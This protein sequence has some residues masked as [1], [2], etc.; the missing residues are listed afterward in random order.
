MTYY[1]GLLTSANEP[2]GRSLTFAYDA[3]R[4]LSGVTDSAGRSVVYTYDSNGNL[5]AVKDVRDGIIQYQYDEQG[6][7]TIIDPD[8][9]MIWINSYDSNSRVAW[10]YDSYVNETAFNHD[11]ANL[12]T[13]MTDPLGNT[14]TVSYDDKYRGTGITYPGGITEN[15]TYDANNCP[16]SVTDALN[17]TTNYE[18]DGSGNLKY[19]TDPA[20]QV[21]SMDYDGKNNLVKVINAKSKITTLTYDTDHINLKEVIDPLGR[22]TTYDFYSNGL[23]HTKKT[24]DPDPGT[25]IYDYQ[26]GLLYTLTDPVGNITTCGYDNFGYLHTITDTAGKT[27]AMNYDPAGNLT[28]VTDPLGYNT[29]FTYDYRH[30]I[31]TKTDARGFVTTYSYNGNGQLESVLDALNNMTQY[32]YDADNRL[33]KI[34]DARGNTTT[35]SYNALG[36]LTGTTDPLGNTTGFQYNDA[37]ILTIKTDAKGIKVLE[38]TYNELDNPKKMTD[39]LGKFVSFDEYD[40]LGSLTKYTDSNG[41]STQFEYNDLNSL[42]KTTVANNNIGSQDFDTHGNRVSLI[43]PNNNTVSF[44]YD[45]ADRLRSKSTVSAGSISMEYNNRNLLSLKTNARGQITT[46]EYD[47][48]G[49]LNSFTNPDGTTS[50]IYDQNGNLLT[51]TDSTGTTGRVYDALNRLFKYTDAQGNIIQYGYDAVGNLLTLTYPGGR[52][53]Q[54]GYDAA[55]QLKTVTD[56]SGRITN[57]DYDVNGRLVKTTRPDGTVETREYNDAGQLTQLKD[58]YADGSIINRY[59]YTY[60]DAGN[61]KTDNNTNESDPFTTNNAVLTYAADNRLDT[62]EGQ[63]VQYDADGNMTEGPLAENMVNFTFDARSRLTG[64]GNTSYTYDALNNRVR[65]SDG[66]QQTSYTINPNAPLSQVLIQTD[67]ENTKT[68]FVYGLGLIGQETGGDYRSYHFDHLGSTIALTDQSGNVTDCFRYAPYGE[69]LYRSGN[70]TTP[71]LFNGR[72]GVMTDAYDLYYMR[73]R[74]YNPVAKRFISPDTL[75]G[76]ITNPQSQN[77]YIYCEGNPVNYVDPMGFSISNYRVDYPMVYSK[78]FERFDSYEDAYQYYLSLP[79]RI[80][81]QV[82]KNNNCLLEH[83]TIDLYA[84]YKKNQY[85][86]EFYVLN[87]LIIAEGE[88]YNLDAKKEAIKN[89]QEIEIEETPIIISGNAGGASKQI[90]AGILAQNRAAGKAAELIV[91]ERLVG[92]GSKIIGSQVS[93][94]TPQG[95]RRTDHLIRDIND[96][97][98]AIEVKSGNATRNAMQIAKDIFIETEGGI[99]VGSNAGDLIGQNVKIITI[100]ERVP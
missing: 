96:N 63:N 90:R 8:D 14:I 3:S 70:I 15:F 12:Q 68:Y 30:N 16:K 41:V 7:T 18:Y 89:L 44:D 100:I 79:H 62:Y 75:L 55:N 26:N 71:F 51:T 38:V 99:L 91:A 98:I 54:Y 61:I 5:A 37:G 2:A 74:Y 67:E 46:Y 77:R 4:R 43:D 11:T 35:C 60:D 76:V 23:L 88:S 34:I 13:A 36:R 81:L 10:L 45:S 21:T 20:G 24:P 50:Y 97:L 29:S 53:V 84:L 66:V 27:T 48:A 58:T 78:Y 25:T 40:N 94:R 64:G 42:H 93:V 86:R 6:L 65:V 33:E 92:Q 47:D 1:D 17:H 52:Q 49:R 56:W 57:Y 95:I 80:Y 83:E 31:L 87:E 39:A 69:L 59:D 85:E 73:A 82:V 19:I 32:K 22:I 28:G 72:D 9:N